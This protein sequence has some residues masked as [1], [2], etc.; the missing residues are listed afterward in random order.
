MSGQTT[1]NKIDFY[2]EMIDKINDVRGETLNLGQ[3][4]FLQTS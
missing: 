4:H 1:I 2:Y 3:A